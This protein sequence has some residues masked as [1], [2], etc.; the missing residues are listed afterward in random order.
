MNGAKALD[1][2]TQVRLE[3]SRERPRNI[4]QLEVAFHGRRRIHAVGVFYNFTGDDTD[5]VESEWNKCPHCGAE[6]TRLPG[7][8]RIETLIMEGRTFVEY[9]TARKE[10]N[11]GEL[12]PEGPSGNVNVTLDPLEAALGELG[13][14]NSPVHCAERDFRSTLQNEKAILHLQCCGIQL[15]VRGKE[16]I[17]RLR[18]M[19]NEGILIS[20]REKVHRME[21]RFLTA[22]NN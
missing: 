10:T 14:R 19:A 8:A 1:P 6:L 2:P 13:E 18:E 5:N 12:K 21:L 7:T 16:G 3:A 20:G 17:A 4:G 9:V 15:F 11:M 22:W